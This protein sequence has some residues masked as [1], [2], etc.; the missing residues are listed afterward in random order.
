KV[1]LSIKTLFSLATVEAKSGPL[2]LVNGATSPAYNKTASLLDVDVNANLKLSVLPI[3]LVTVGILETGILN[4]ATTGNS[5]PQSNSSASVNDV[6]LELLG[7]ALLP[8]IAGITA[9]EIA[10]TAS[11]TGSCDSGLTA[12]GTTSLV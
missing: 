1:D 10:S 5:A 3:P 8:L 12:S 6:N 9:E 4:V 11:A 7:A 2:P